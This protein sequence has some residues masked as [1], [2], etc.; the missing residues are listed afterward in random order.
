MEKKTH[1]G[2]SSVHFL[3]AH[4]YSVQSGTPLIGGWRSSWWKMGCLQTCWPSQILCFNTLNMR[5]FDVEAQTEVNLDQK[6]WW[7]NTLKIRLFVLDLLPLSAAA[8]LQSYGQCVEI[9]KLNVHL[10]IR[11]RCVSQ[12]RHVVEFHDEALIVWLKCA[13][14]APTE[15]VTQTL[16][17][18][19]ISSFKVTLKWTLASKV[20]PHIQS[21]C[22]GVWTGKIR[23][24]LVGCRCQRK[25][26]IPM[27]RARKKGNQ[28][29][30]NMPTTTPSVLAAF[31]SLE[32][33]SS[34]TV[35]V[36]AP[37]PPALEAGQVSCWFLQW[38]L[39]VSSLEFSWRSFITPASR[40]LVVRL[41]TT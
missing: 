24:G 29:R 32:N 13:S 18:P 21:L 23:C 8:F 20:R 27:G 25:L 37:L 4:Y 1:R 11:T 15:P 2:T 35:S 14:D 30:M 26:N 12:L 39:R 34:L 33:L 36:P 16:C 19:P 9:M 5:R 3:S 10:R 40:F 31:F 17:S 38:I 22:S 28:Q 6:L 41:A 7:V